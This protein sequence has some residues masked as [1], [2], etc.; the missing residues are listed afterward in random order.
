[1]DARD[2]LEFTVFGLTAGGI[3][4]VSASGLVVTYATTGVFN[5]AHGAVGMMAAFL[6]WQL[7]VE[8]GWPAPLAIVLIVVVVAPLF[9]LLIERLLIR[10]LYGASLAT[11]L[12]VTVGL[13]VGLIGIAGERW[14]PQRRVVSPFF[15]GEGFDLL[16]V[17]VTWHRAITFLVAVAVAVGLRILLY[18][19]R[20]GTTMRATVD[21]RDL[22]ALN[23][24]RPAWAGAAAWALGASLAALAGILLASAFSSLDIIVITLLVVDAYAAAV[25][26]RLRSLPLTFLGAMILGLLVNYTVGYLP[27]AFADDRL[28]RYLQSLPSAIPAIMLFVVLLLL[29]QARLRGSRLISASKVKVA[30]FGASLLGGV[31]LVVAAVLVVQFVSRDNVFE[32]GKGLGLSLVILSLLPLT[33]YAGQVSLGQLAFAGVGAWAMVEFGDTSPW[34]GLL[35]AVVITAAVGAIV[36]LPALRL[37][38]LYLALMTLAFAVFME[39]LIFPLESMFGPGSNLVPR[40]DLPWLSMDSQGT[41][42]VFMAVVYAL[43]AI[44]ILAMRRAAFGRRLIAM[45]DSPA[46]CAT[47]GMSTNRTKLLVFTMSA[48]IAGLGGAVYWG[49]TGTV[50]AVEFTMV[51][52]LLILLLAVIGGVSTASGALLGGF[53]FALITIISQEVPE[54]DWLPAIAPAVVGISLARNPDGAAAEIAGRLRDQF[55]G[56]RTRADG[57]MEH[58]PLAD[59]DAS[60]PLGADLTPVQVEA[61]DRELAIEE[62]SVASH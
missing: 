25:V 26:G 44:G 27:Y 48:A 51:A 31:V 11:T 56:R 15:Q 55:F 7:T 18:N 8:W 23:G 1:V 60:L 19:T 40:L 47:L 24:A 41:Y 4:F 9:G 53:F 28:P 37:D 10:G 12:V 49:F 30:S 21:D 22:V 13:L 42:F 16:G 29:P 46:A 58:D 20:I 45:R 57:D 54:L 43:L 61:L 35:M 62:V 2:F 17:F 6:Y 36:S 33:G 14:P 50:T 38:G 39:V 59:L 32:L 34:L 5:F 3:F 52:S